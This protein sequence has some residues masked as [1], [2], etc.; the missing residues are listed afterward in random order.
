MRINLPAARA[1]VYQYMYTL[2]L[3]GMESV[4][5]YVFE[6]RTGQEISNNNNNK[7]RRARCEKRK[8]RRLGKDKKETDSEKRSRKI[9]SNRGCI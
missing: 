2:S 4:A 8:I 7:K 6:I 9:E 5:Y 3:P 1:T